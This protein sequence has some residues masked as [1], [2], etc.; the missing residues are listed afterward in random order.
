MSFFETGKDYQK[1]ART[2]VQSIIILVVVL[3]LINAFF[4][5]REYVTYQEQNIQE[6][7]DK[8]FV[9]LSYLG[10]DRSGTS[11][12]ISTEQ[13]G[14]ELDALTQ[15]GF[16]TITQD[17]ISDFYQ[18]EKDLPEK[19][20]FL[21]FEDGRRDTAIFAQD[22]LEEN[23]FKATMLTYAQKFEDNEQKFLTPKDVLMLKEQSF[24]EFGSNGYRLSYINVFD[25]YDH[26]LGELSSLEYNQIKPYLGRNYNQYLMD[27]IRDEN[28]IPLESTKQ[29]TRRIQYD[30]E[31]MQ[32]VYT[33]EIGEMPKLYAIMHAN[34]GR[35][36]NNDKVSKVNEACVLENFQ[37]N[38]NREGYS[39]NT[40]ESS[41]YDLTRMQVQAYW[42]TNHLLMRLLDDTEYEIQ[43]VDG[44]SARKHK[45]ETIQGASEFVEDRIIITSVSEGYG[46]LR[47]KDSENI[48]DC[49]VEAD[50]TGNKLGIQTIY[51]RSNEDCSEAIAITIDSNVLYVNQISDNKK[52]IL[53]QINLDELDGIEYQSIEENEK[54]ALV[55]E[56]KTIAKYAPTKGKQY[57]QAHAKMLEAE[58]IQVKSVTDGVEP[59]IPE[60]QIFEEGNRHVKLVLFADK[61][62]VYVDDKC[63]FENVAVKEGKG[64]IF[65][66]AAF[67]GYGYS[68]RNIIDDV[69]DGVFEK[70]EITTV[71][72]GEESDIIYS[73]KLKK[74]EIFW[75]EIKR[76]WNGIINWFIDT[77]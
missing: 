35:F 65:L 52:K 54:E 70:F 15:N 73:N 10:V 13:L 4:V 63:A 55:E 6:V 58:K 24:W 9:A 27:F 1:A 29:M 19:S 7:Q 50:L 77:F 68:Q 49:V 37:M 42:S 72:I 23:N 59:Y 11:S 64:S 18:N 48:S 62:M 30:Y 22:E 53:A 17:D 71:P 51:L 45:W 69:Y 67:A 43:F 44:D 31:L 36:G 38:F 32:K 57:E 56:Y 76:I 5:L 20:L 2:V 28:D 46:R 8:G 66:E 14:K 39:W 16:V 3:V 60:I 25:R 21:L 12:L 34:T 47:L 61:L 41:I 40:S 75:I 74:S 26:Y 33:E